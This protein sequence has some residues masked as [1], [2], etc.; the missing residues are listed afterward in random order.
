MK[1]LLTKNWAL[2]LFGGMLCLMFFLGV[3]ERYYFQAGVFD[4]TK[5]DLTIL[6]FLSVLGVYA[7]IAN[8]AMEEIKI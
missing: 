8:K 6:L 3:I 4:K 2:I 7:F 5:N 1:F